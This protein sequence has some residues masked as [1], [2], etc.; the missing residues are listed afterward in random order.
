MTVCV[1]R[2]EE[3]DAD[4][5]A[6]LASCGRP[7]PWVRVALLDDDGNEVPDG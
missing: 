1:L 4:D 2:K 6:R 3:H 7:V 5:L